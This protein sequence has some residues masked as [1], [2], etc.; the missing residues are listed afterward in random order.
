MNYAL[1]ADGVLVVLLII[2]L[3]VGVKRGFVK[4]ILKFAGTLFAIVFAFFFCVN[5]VDFLE[6]T[7]GMV[8]F[9][10][11]EVMK[12]FSGNELMNVPIDGG[13]LAE[14]FEAAKIPGFIA[15]GIIAAIG[16]QEIPAETTVNML[17]SPVLAK[18]MSIAIA[19]I[20][21]IILVKL[22]VVIV[23]KVLSALI[24]R[25]PVINSINALLGGILGL[26]KMCI[27]LFLIFA[28]LHWLNIPSVNDFFA[29]SVIIKWFYFS[30]WFENSINYFISMQWYNDYFADL[31]NFS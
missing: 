21:L 2:A 26:A 9:F 28:V 31:F 25:I 11:G 3:F 19:F 18:W 16:E 13:N 15:D 12:W 6:R 29:Q 14:A 27:G 7:F 20:A 4:G 24:E 22:A 10:S 17:V 30:E 23:G 5:F 8:T 1:I